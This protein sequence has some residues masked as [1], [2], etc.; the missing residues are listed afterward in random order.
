MK[1][2]IGKD[3]SIEASAEIV[4][5]IQR[6]FA[7]LKETQKVELEYD[8]YFIRFW[9]VDHGSGKPSINIQIQEMS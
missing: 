6:V 7:I 5:K 8:K 4:L 2:K 1:I 3:I 9:R